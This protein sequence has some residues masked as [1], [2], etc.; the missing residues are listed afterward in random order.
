L[1]ITNKKGIKMTNLPEGFYFGIVESVYGSCHQ[2][3]SYERNR[4]N[5]RRKGNTQ[6]LMIIVSMEN[7]KQ[8]HACLESFQGSP[9]NHATQAKA[10]NRALEMEKNYLGKKAKM[11][12][13]P[14]NTWS[15]L[16]I[17]EE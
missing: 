17:I 4:R 7:G 11:Y 2:N 1:F 16:R 5:Y 12:L 10:N 15:F 6:S 14:R 8:V 3:Y 9:D 13:S